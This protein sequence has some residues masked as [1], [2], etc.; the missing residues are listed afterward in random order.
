M[1]KDLEK[2]AFSVDAVL[3][4]KS[5]KYRLDY[6]GVES[7]FNN[8]RE[9]KSELSLIALQQETEEHHFKCYGKYDFVFYWA[10]IQTPG[11]Y[12]LGGRGFKPKFSEVVMKAPSSNEKEQWLFYIGP[13]PNVS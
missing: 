10:K 1:F 3:R 5:G 12:G 9:V 2:E 11:V 8:L 6:N 4:K 7:Q 13:I